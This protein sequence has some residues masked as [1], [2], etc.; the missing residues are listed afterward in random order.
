MKF[1][2][3]ALLIAKKIEKDKGEK[4]KIQTKDEERAKACGNGC[5]FVCLFVLLYAV[6]TLFGPFNAE[7]S[8]FDKSFK[9]FNLVWLLFCLDIVKRQNS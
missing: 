9:Q 4:E 7:L 1:S 5:L 8:H 3:N 6:S 2:F